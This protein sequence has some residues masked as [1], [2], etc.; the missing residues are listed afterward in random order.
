MNGGKMKTDQS[1]PLISAYLNDKGISRRAFLKATAATGAVVS[2][3][4]GMLPKMKAL[5]AASAVPGTMAARYLSRM[6]LL[7]FQAGICD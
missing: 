6:H 4:S 1:T 5:A 3:G 7:V 2:L